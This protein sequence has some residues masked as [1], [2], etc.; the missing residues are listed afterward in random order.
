[1]LFRFITIFL[2][3]FLFQLS[4]SQEIVTDTIQIKFTA[5]T[6]F[7]AN[8]YWQSATDK[9]GVNPKLVSY[10][11]KKK[12]ILIP[13]DQELCVQKELAKLIGNN[14]SKQVPT[15]T[16][17]LEIDYFT[18]E[19][20]NGRFIDPY[21]LYA[22]MPLKKLVNGTITDVGVLTYNY[23]FKPYTKTPFNIACE[24]VLSNWHQQFKIDMISVVNYTRTNTE[25]PEF[26][27]TENFDKPWFFNFTLG[28]ALGLSVIN[29]END[30][31]FF[32]QLEG[33][34]HFTRP[35]TKPGQWYTGSFIRYQNTADFEMIGF[36]KKLEHYT[37]RLS[38]KTLIDISTN[39]LIGLNK[40]KDTED[41]KLWEILQFSLSSAQS[42]NFDKKNAD[43]LILKAGLFENFYYII[44]KKYGIQVGPYLSVGYKF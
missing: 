2:A 43:G 22:D 30:P 25:K 28:G 20:Y 35:E 34:I 9:R 17:L 36:G 26:L 18:I 3:V 38:D 31:T 23:E 5:D 41:V 40:W 7:P 21:V 44:P 42:F 33:E 6:I 32:W 11:Q 19:K 8:Y 37:K 15:D 29:S 10:S 1:M 24:Q 4:H 13:V 12:Y 27:I 14:K 16:F 39:T